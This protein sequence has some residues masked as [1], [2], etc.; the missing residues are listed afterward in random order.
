MDKITATHNRLVYA[1]VCMKVDVDQKI[2]KSIDV[3]MKDGFVASIVV[4][5]PWIPP[6]LGHSKNGCP[7]KPITSNKVWVPKVPPTGETK[8]LENKVVKAYSVGVEGNHTLSYNLVAENVVEAGL[9]DS[10]VQ[11]LFPNLHLANLRGKAIAKPV[12]LN[13]ASKKSKT[14]SSNRFSIL[15]S[16]LDEYDKMSFLVEVVG[17]WFM[18]AKMKVVG[19]VVDNNM[20][21]RQQLPH[22]THE[23]VRKN[24]I[25]YLRPA[26]VHDISK[27]ISPDSC[28]SQGIN[29]TEIL[30]VVIRLLCQEQEMLGNYHYLSTYEA[31]S[32]RDLGSVVE[33]EFAWRGVSEFE[34][35]KETL[36]AIKAVL[37]DAEEQAGNHELNLWLE[38]FKDACYEVEDLLD[39][40]EIEALRRQVLERGSTGRK[41]RHFFSG[42][43]P[44]A[45]RFRMGY[46]IKKANEILNEIASKKTKF[47]LIEKHETKK[48]MHSERETYSVVK[49]SDVIGRDEDKEMIIEFL[50]HSTDGEDIP[51]LPIVGIGGLGKT[52]LAQLVFNDEKVN[53]HFELR[54]WV[55]VAEDFDI[56]ELMI[57]II[58]S[59][60]GVKC[61]DMNKEELHKVL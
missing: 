29:G 33:I 38:R 47:H 28:K 32:C 49:T 51:V 56:K 48:V 5:V 53:M 44:L 54:I 6:S 31:N 37:L 59:A 58:K 12:Q 61:K 43:N 21:I 11:E 46:K 34:K 55:C 8:N 35:L 9:G 10:Q 60:T 23:V 40:F 13:K 41:V 57:K 15:E 18:V 19:S 45:F 14:G 39:E 4:D 52:A 36:T 25:Q 27:L 50:M 7:M 42:S 1:K 16:E 26:L 22:N 20:L 30:D 17:S 2:P 3:G 24:P